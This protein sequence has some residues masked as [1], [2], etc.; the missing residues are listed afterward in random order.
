M[1]TSGRRRQEQKWKKARQP[2]YFCQWP[3]WLALR[4]HKRAEKRKRHQEKSTKRQ[5]IQRE[6]LQVLDFFCENPGRCLNEECRGTRDDTRKAHWPRGRR[7]GWTT[8][9][10]DGKTYY[11]HLHLTL[12]DAGGWHLTVTAA[13][14]DDWWRGSL[15]SA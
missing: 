10:G 13:A 14:A 6:I 7:S 12:L 11:M 5:D 8:I 3:G 1:H 9:S 15:F 4:R 2:V